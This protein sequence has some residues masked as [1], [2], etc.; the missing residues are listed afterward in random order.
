MNY[1]EMKKQTHKGWNTWNNRSVLS[2]VHLPDAF[3][4]TVGIK[5]YASGNHL[6]E[7]LIGRFEKNTEVIKPSFHAYDGSYTELDMNWA[8]CDYNIK[9]A[10][11]DDDLVILIT[12]IINSVRTPVLSIEAA[13]LWGKD[14]YV[15]REDGVLTG[16]L[17]DKQVEVYHTGTKVTEPQIYFHSPYDAVLLDQKI[18]ISTGKQRCL[19]EIESIVEAKKADYQKQFKKYGDNAEVYKAMQSCLA[20]DT[21]YEPNKD[22][23]VSPVSRLWSNSSGG[24]VLFCWDTYFAALMAMVENKELAY[25]NA[26]EITREKTENGFV[27]NFAHVTGFKSRDRSQPPVGSYVINRIYDKYKEKWF[28]EEVFDDLYIWNRWWFENR[29]ICDGLFA[30]GS[31]AYKPVVGNFWETHNLHNN[32]GASLESGLDNSPMYDDMEFDENTNMMQLAD[33]G[34]TSLV[35][36]DCKSLANIANELGREQ[37]Y[38]QLIKSI[39]LIQTNMKKLWS[40]EKGFFYNYDMT[41]KEFS[42]RISPTNFYALYNDDIP[43]EDVQRIVNEHFYNEKEFWGEYILP[44]ISRDDPAFYDNTYWRGRIWA[45]MNMLAYIGLKH[46]K[47]SQKAAKDLAIKSKDL[48]L[49][50]WLEFG[51]VHENYNAVTGEGCDVGNSDKFYHWGG[52]LSYV[53][54]EE[55]GLI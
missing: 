15:K 45:P 8:S 1:Q 46:H 53:F 11:V 7:V 21:I 30:W 10:T 49:K 48:I 32:E 12:P 3:T 50:E 2:Y 44:S 17:A 54:L 38:S 24:C 51:H 28:L 33:V 52:L 25:S 43:E 19:Q 37:E 4:V 20:W 22:R 18:G 55:E 13:I 14:G 39:E 16:F 42:Y 40:K 34:L 29:Q 26:I 23:I 6:N 36:L 47:A 5:D 27:P 31:N 35:L 9:T 41:K